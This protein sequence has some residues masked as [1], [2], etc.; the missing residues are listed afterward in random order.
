MIVAEYGP[1]RAVCTKVQDGDTIYLKMDLG[2]NMHF[3]A[4][5]QVN[6]MIA[7]DA[8]TVA[9]GDSRNYAA[10][11]LP[12]GTSCMV[13]SHSYDAKYVRFSGTITLPDGRDFAG[14]MIAAGMATDPNAPVK[15]PVALKANNLTNS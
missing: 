10:G 11:L 4:I 12:V 1:Y 2:F 15:K 14:A 5:C 9:G 7:P 3:S 6:G 13:V 8:K